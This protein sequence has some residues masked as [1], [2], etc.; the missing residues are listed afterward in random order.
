MDSPSR[1]CAVDPGDSVDRAATSAVSQVVLGPRPAGLGPGSL[2][3][4]A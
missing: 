2:E 1:V 3:V 4:G